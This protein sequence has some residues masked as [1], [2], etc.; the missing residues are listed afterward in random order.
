MSNFIVRKVAVLGL[1]FKPESDDVRDSPALDVAVQLNGR[2]A[3]VVATDPEAIENSRLL[4]PQLSFTPDIEAALTGAEVVVVVTEWRQFR[5]IDPARAASLLSLHRRGRSPYS[6]V[7][8]SGR[9]RPC[10]RR[11]CQP[12]R[13]IR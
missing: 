2:G 12:F 3:D 5:A 11:G 1:S 7:K 13:R 4:Q 8:R 9:P 10:E 6:N